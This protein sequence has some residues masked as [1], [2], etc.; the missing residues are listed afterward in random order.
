M[1]ADADINIRKAVITSLTTIAYNLPKLF[2]DANPKFYDYIKENLKIV[3]SLIKE[4]EL[5]PFKHKVDDGLPLRT[6]AYSFVETS[7]ES[8]LPLHN[9]DAGLYNDAILGGLGIDLMFVLF[10]F[11]FQILDENNDDILIICFHIIQ[12]LCLINPYIILSI[13]DQITDKMKVRVEKFAKNA[14]GKQEGDRNSDLFRAV[15]RCC[16]AISKTPDIETCPKFYDFFN[17]TQKN[18]LVVEIIKSL[19]AN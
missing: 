1:I 8:L 14:V 15:V 6:S 2:K 5:G 9:I 17:E 18:P 12:K 13:I 11:L 10:L 3:A 19:Q 7:V 4:V 16:L